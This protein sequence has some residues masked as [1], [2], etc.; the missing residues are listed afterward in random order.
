MKTIASLP[1]NY[2]RATKIEV[3]LLFNFGPTAQFKRFIFDNERKQTRAN[4]C[5]SVEMKL[6][7]GEK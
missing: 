7:E 5:A 4:P 1:R 2:L 3:G 6:P